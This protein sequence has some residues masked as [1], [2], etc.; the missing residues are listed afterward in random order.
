[1]SERL[2]RRQTKAAFPD[3]P[4]DT[5][6]QTGHQSKLPHF[7][8]A[9][10][11]GFNGDGSFALYVRSVRLTMETTMQ[12]TPATSR[13]AFSLDNREWISCSHWGLFPVPA[14]SLET[15]GEK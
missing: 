1:M 4:S 3:R 15:R 6:H 10:N 7:L 14:K 8:T 12:S 2:C 9:L 11:Q 13:S 5:P